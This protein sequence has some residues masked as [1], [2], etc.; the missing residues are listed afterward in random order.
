M[1]TT[2]EVTLDKDE[3]RARLLGGD[4]RLSIAMATGGRYVR[5]GLRGTGD[6]ELR[7]AFDV[8]DIEV[9]GGYALAVPGAPYV[10]R[11]PVDGWISISAR[12]ARPRRVR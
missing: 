9:R 2:I 7:F 1:T 6:V 4:D 12:R 8:D 11:A 3:P 10:V 5:V